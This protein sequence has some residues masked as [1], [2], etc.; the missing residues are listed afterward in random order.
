MEEQARFQ[1][2]DSQSESG[3][4]AATGMS[5][6]KTQVLDNKFRPRTAFSGNRITSVLELLRTYTNI[7]D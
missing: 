6:I 7:R 5:E 2:L 1:I 3:C 4:L